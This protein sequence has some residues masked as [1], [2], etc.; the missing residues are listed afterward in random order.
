MR[1]EKSKQKSIADVKKLCYPFL[2]YTNIQTL[3]IGKSES[4]PYL[5]NDKVEYVFLDKLIKTKV[6]ATQNNLPKLLQDLFKE[7][8][9]RILC[10]YIEK[11]NNYAKS[12]NL[13][14][15]EWESVKDILLVSTLALALT[16]NLS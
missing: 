12:K 16:L 15:G 14:F 10:H 8:V 7:P 4:D 5:S 9:K 2:P 3:R 11:E 6:L 13:R 1:Q